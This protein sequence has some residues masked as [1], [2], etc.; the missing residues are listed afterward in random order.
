MHFL[1]LNVVFITLKLCFVTG[2]TSHRCTMQLPIFINFISR[3]T[4]VLNHFLIPAYSP[5]RK[6]YPMQLHFHLLLCFSIWLKRVIILLCLQTKKLQC[7]VQQTEILFTQKRTTFAWLGCALYWQTYCP[8]YRLRLRLFFFMIQSSFP[9]LSLSHTHT[10]TLLFACCIVL[11]K[12]KFFLSIHT[13]LICLFRAC[14]C[15]C[16]QVL[17]QHTIT[18]LLSLNVCIVFTVYFLECECLYQVVTIVKGM[19]NNIGTGS[20]QCDQ[21]W[22]NFAALAKV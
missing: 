4:R 13:H 8:C 22:P 1:H 3:E 20:Q 15:D 6:E 19:N 17:G 7:F 16:V 5:W 12:I 21:I 14:E 9:S 18:N 2:G 11:S 10:H